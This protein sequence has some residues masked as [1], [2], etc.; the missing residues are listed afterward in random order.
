MIR[1]KSKGVLFS[2]FL[3]VVSFSASAQESY[4]DAENIVSIGGAVTE[5][6]YA[7]GQEHRLTAR[8]TTSVFPPEVLELPDVGYMRRLS[9]EGILSVSPDLILTEPGSG[10]QETIELLANADIPF[11]DVPGDYSSEG[12]L[13]RITTVSAVLGVEE[14]GAE[15]AAEVG[16]ALSAAE[17]TA[18]AH[19]EKPR[20]LFILSMPGG[21]LNVSGTGTRADGIIRMAG[22]I[23]AIDE[24]D[25]YRILTDE[26]VIEAAPDIILMMTA[27][28]GDHGVENDQV[29]DVPSIQL[30]P[31]GENHAMVRMDGSLMLG[32]GPRT[33]EAITIL[34]AAFYGE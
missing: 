21:K 15:L 28:G 27:R 25:Q 8:D 13:Q 4:P 5:I 1:T 26:A 29:W 17:Q 6:V 20:V 9:P 23:N 11:V 12:I 10:P 3:G 14:R 31:A 32:F 24:F 19:D 2:A 30:T 16:A 22:G 7:L 34:S 33:A 18:Q